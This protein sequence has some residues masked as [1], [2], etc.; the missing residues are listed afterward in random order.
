L[1]ASLTCESVARAALGEPVRRQGAEIFYRAPWRDDQKP[2]LQISSAKNVWADFPAGLSGTAWQL[3]AKLAECDPSDK[4]TVKTWLETHGLQNGNGNGHGKRTAGATAKPAPAQN[5]EPFVR[6]AEFYYGENLRTVRM[7]RPNPDGG[8][9]EKIFPWQ[10]LENGKWVSGDGGLQ[11][12]LYVNQVFR[13]RDQLGLVLGFEGPAKADAA[14]ELGFAAFSFKGFTPAHCEVLADCDIVFF[15]DKDEP[16]DRQ[17]KAAA[18]LLAQSKQQVRR[19]RIVAPPGELPEAGD[20][21]DGIRDFAWDA[22]R[23]RALINEAKPFAA[24]PEAA[25]PIL[26]LTE[27]GN[28]ERFAANY[29]PDVRFCHQLNQWFGWDEKRFAPDETAQVERLAKQVVGRLYQDAINIEGKDAREAMLK[30]AMRSDS[31]HGIRALLNRAAAEEG[32]PVRVEELDANGWLLNVRKGTV[33]LHSGNL[34]PHRRGDLITKLADIDFDAKAT[35][36]RWRQ[37]LLEIFDGNDEVIDFLH[38]ALGYSLTGDTREECLFLLYGTGRNG[39]G[40]LIKTVQAALGDY[41]GTTDFS[42]FIATK[43]DRGP[44]DDVANM[45]GRRFVVSQEVREGAPLAESLVKWL[46]GGDRVRARNLYARST[47]WDPTH[48]LWLAVNSKPVIRG[49]DPGIWS[50]IRL[51]PFSVC[52]DGREDRTLKAKLLEELPGILGWLVKGCL[53]WQSEGLSECKTVE[54]ATAEYRAESDNFARFIE[55]FCIVGEF[56]T[57]KSRMLYTKYRCCSEAAGE[58]P[59]SE[60][61]FGLKLGEK[62]FVKKHTSA[63]ALYLGIGL[64]AEKI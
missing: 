47:E 27:I 58:A 5:E 45:R 51:V 9:P 50:R 25:P 60:T 28:A 21:I 52:F 12:P 39:K 34:L 14:G 13:D 61:Q 22:D 54:D 23:I 2:S 64:K 49:T 35:C 46:T 43:D 8:K 63:G 4:P 20:I 42:T 55:E 32:I 1:T 62:G 17:A 26:R 6:V 36:P 41:A 16:G 30:F 40:T 11:K 48:H 7:E 10:H 59:V 37:F 29:G 44:R 24:E 3:A 18:D 19:I 57:G 31:D 38:R 15:P 33:D 56:A 53:R